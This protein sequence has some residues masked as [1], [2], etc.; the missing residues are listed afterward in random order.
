MLHAGVDLHKRQAQVA[1]VNDEGTVRSNCAV[2]CD[3]DTM[4]GLFSSLAQPAQVVMEATS[5]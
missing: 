4:L 5:P 1:V 3:R 2:A